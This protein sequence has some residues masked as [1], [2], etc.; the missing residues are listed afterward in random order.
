M[1]CPGAGAG[2]GAGAGVGAGAGA[3]AGTGAGTATATAAAATAAAAAAAAGAAD[4]GAL[5]YCAGFIAEVIDGAKVSDP[6]TAAA[7][8]KLQTAHQTLFRI[9]RGAVETPRTS[10]LLVST[11]RRMFSLGWALP[12]P[13]ACVAVERERVRPFG[14]ARAGAGAGAGGWRR[15]LRQIRPRCREGV[16]LSVRAGIGGVAAGLPLA[17]AAQA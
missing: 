12:M 10:R 11:A 5:L 7:L 15:W 2:A 6:E 4:S 3:G 16:L 8:E 17:G 13:D 1:R 9:R 14:R